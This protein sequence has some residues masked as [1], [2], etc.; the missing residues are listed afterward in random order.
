MPKIKVTQSFS[1]A[2]RGLYV[3]EYQVGEEVE[4]S[5]ECAAVAIAEKWA[6][7]DKPKRAP[8]KA[9]ETIAAEMAPEVK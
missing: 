1:F 5:E 6:T 9:P 8:A 3:T 2:E 7:A 4:V